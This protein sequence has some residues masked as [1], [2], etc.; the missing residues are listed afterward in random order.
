VLGIATALRWTL[1]SFSGVKDRREKV[2]SHIW[3][4]SSVALL[5]KVWVNQ[6]LDILLV[7]A[8]VD[9]QL[10]VGEFV[11]ISVSEFPELPHD[12]SDVGGIEAE[13]STAEVL[14][15]IVYQRLDTVLWDFSHSDIF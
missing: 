5:Q 10:F 9:E 4:V 12:K 3:Q 15:H 13:Q 6:L 2:R 1:I 14:G 8:S 11:N 7:T